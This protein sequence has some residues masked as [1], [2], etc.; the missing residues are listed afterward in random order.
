MNIVFVHLNTKVPMYLK[1]NI[2]RTI[3]LF[4]NHKVWLIHN[5]STLK[6]E[7]SGLSTFSVHHDSR[8]EE[9]NSLHSHPKEFR[10][11]FW[12]T[13]SARLLALD[14]FMTANQQECLHL[15][16]DVVIS[17]DFPFDKLQ[18]QSKILSYPLM[19]EARG[20][21]SVI[22]MRNERASKVMVSTLIDDA[23]KDSQST[24]MLSLRNAADKNPEEFQLLPIGPSG[25]A[26]YR[27]IS[28]EMG[29]KL[30]QAISYFGG[31]FDGVEIG[32]FFFGT[33]PRNR[34]GISLMRQD[35]AKGYCGVQKWELNYNR[36]RHFPDL[37]SQ[38]E[39]V[40][41]STPIFALHLPSKEIS[42]F[43]QQRQGVAL[44]RRCVESTKSPVN[45]IILNKVMIAGISAINR[46]F[47]KV[48]KS[49]N[50]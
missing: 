8:W 15:E 40:A 28:V 25:L 36:N 32:Q 41:I 19:S 34:R 16:S 18:N 11:N 49:G 46:R 9:L 27:D 14:E 22:Y 23:R 29:N 39:H 44:R 37:I 2:Q 13:S 43:S 45:R 24:E 21:G 3:N 20:V 10:G 5:S 7:I 1:K 33:D 48:I 35:I 42:L 4:P 38:S 47:L 31:I 50:T 30:S 6:S 26:N 12:F 17:T